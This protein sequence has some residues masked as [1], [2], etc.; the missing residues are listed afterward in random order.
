MVANLTNLEEWIKLADR[1]VTWEGKFD[2]SSFEGKVVG[3]VFDLC[4]K[5][6]QWLVIICG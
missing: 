3:K 5:Y 2:Q 1:V 4:H 6:K